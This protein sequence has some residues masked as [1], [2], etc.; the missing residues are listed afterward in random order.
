MNMN[1]IN[2]ASRLINRLDSMTEQE[3]ITIAKDLAANIGWAKYHQTDDEYIDLYRYI[4]Q[5]LQN[6]GSITHNQVATTLTKIIG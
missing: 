1:Q 2:R 4:I 5:T 6:P 3:Q